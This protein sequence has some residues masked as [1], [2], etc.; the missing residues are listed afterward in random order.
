MLLAA[1]L[2]VAWPARGADSAKAKDQLARRPLSVLLFTAGPT[3]EYQFVRTVFVRETGRH[4][5]N[6]SIYLQGSRANSVQDVPPERMLKR[7]PST[8]RDHEAKGESAYDN[9]AQY[10]VI[11]A[12]DPDWTGLTREQLRLLERWVNKRGGGLIVVGG[13]V[14]TYQL[15][16][17]AQRD[18]LKPVLDL[19]PVIVEDMRLDDG[20]S[21]RSAEAAWLLHFPGATKKMEFLKLHEKGHEPLAGW[22]EF[23]FG[24]GGNKDRG[25]KPASRGFYGYYPVK[26]AKASATVVATFSDPRARLGNGQ[27]QPYL[28]SM[29]YGKGRTV[30]LGSGEMWRLRQYRESCYER[31]WTGLARYAGSGSLSPKAARQR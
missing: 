1:S 26:G 16:R 14:H 27:D 15:A 8:F 12:F 31:F 20:A 11:I 18:R 2:V 24:P 13:P 19:L 4:R 5:A 7:F 17:G 3:R 22:E 29:S 9:L 25:K 6:V 30:W 23:F 10:D 28:V 21:N